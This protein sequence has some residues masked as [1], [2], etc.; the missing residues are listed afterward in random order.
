[1][2]IENSKASEMPFEMKQILLKFVILKEF[3]QKNLHEL[4]P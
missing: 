2:K 4:N 1:M 3:D